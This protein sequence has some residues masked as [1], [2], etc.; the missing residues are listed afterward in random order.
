M[1]CLPPPLHPLQ[2]LSRVIVLKILLHQL[3]DDAQEIL[4]QRKFDIHGVSV[5]T[6]FATGKLVELLES[7]RPP[8]TAS[9]FNDAEL[10]A[11][12]R[13]WTPRAKKDN[14]EFMEPVQLGPLLQDLGIKVNDRA[15]VKL[16]AKKLSSGKDGGAIHLLAFARWWT[17]GIP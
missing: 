8:P 17:C 5:T 11:F 14:P 2:M 4:F 12:V 3:F 6:N 7:E 9:P 13:V 10:N 15:V 16:L 1:P